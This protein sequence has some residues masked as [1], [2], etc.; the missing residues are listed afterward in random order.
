M[1][2]TV[3]REGHQFSLWQPWS[4][5]RNELPRCPLLCNEGGMNDAM[6]ILEKLCKQS[7]QTGAM[8]IFVVGQMPVSTLSQQIP[9]ACSGA[10]SCLFLPQNW[11]ST[12]TRKSFFRCLTA[13]ISF[14][15]RLLDQEDDLPRGLLFNR[16]RPE[17]KKVI[18]NSKE[19][20]QW[21]LCLYKQCIQHLAEHTGANL[22]RPSNL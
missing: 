12:D 18:L 19:V 22:N 3:M 2:T 15:S 6:T 8:A 9:L 20:K 10:G 17:G 5:L 16:V 21:A 4:L 14:S 11:H 1:R 13:T 7:G